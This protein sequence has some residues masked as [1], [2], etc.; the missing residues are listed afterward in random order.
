MRHCLEL[1]SLHLFFPFVDCQL[2][3]AGFLREICLQT[4]IVR[5][6]PKDISHWIYGSSTSSAARTH[7]YLATVPFCLKVCELVHEQ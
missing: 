6:N 5:L 2:R 7:S 3:K 1:F 4:L